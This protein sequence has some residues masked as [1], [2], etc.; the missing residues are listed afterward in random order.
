MK[1]STALIFIASS[2]IKISVQKT[3]KYAAQL[4]SPDRPLIVVE[5]L[6]FGWGVEE[7]P[8]EPMEEDDSTTTSILDDS[9]EDSSDLEEEEELREDPE[10]SPEREPVRRVLFG[11]SNAFNDEDSNDSESTFT[12][13]STDDSRSNTLIGLPVPNIEALPQSDQYENLASPISDFHSLFPNHRLGH[14][15]RGNR[16]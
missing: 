10:V 16:Q 6:P 13:I 14:R 4:D 1:I 5:A 12:V 15:R 8:T 2:L 11:T 3:D 7:E 9:M